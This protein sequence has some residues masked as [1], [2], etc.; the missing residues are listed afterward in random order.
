MLLSP[1]SFYKQNNILGQIFFLN[2]LFFIIVVNG[3]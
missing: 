3:R 2:R 1:F